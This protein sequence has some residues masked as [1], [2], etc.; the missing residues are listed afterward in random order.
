MGYSELSSKFENIWWQ[1]T[2]IE[3]WAS[4][5]QKK[6][7]S[8]SPVVPREQRDGGFSLFRVYVLSIETLISL[9]YYILIVGPL[10]GW[11]LADC[12]RQKPSIGKRLVCPWKDDFNIFGE[13]VT[14]HDCFLSIL[15]D[16]LLL[17]SLFILYNYAIITDWIRKKK[18]SWENSICIRHY[19]LIIIASM[20]VA[21]LAHLC[22]KGHDLQ[23]QTWQQSAQISCIFLI[24]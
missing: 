24:L 20:I 16:F 18:C 5:K 9:H 10:M 6:Y 19:S 14:I 1:I 7:M 2:T 8:R 12:T 17:S 3:P 21:N 11:L 23:I 13:R 15:V 22:H 4:L